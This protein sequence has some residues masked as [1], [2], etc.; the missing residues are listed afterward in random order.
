MSSIQ[1]CAWASKHGS[2]SLLESPL[3]KKVLVTIAELYASDLAFHSHREAVV[4]TLRSRQCVETKGGTLEFPTDCYLNEASVKLFKPAHNRLIASWLESPNAIKLL[5]DVG[6]RDHVSID[7]LFSSLDSLDCTEDPRP[8]VKYLLTIQ[9]KL[10]QSEWQQLKEAR[11][12][13]STSDEKLYAPSELVLRYELQPSL[14]GTKYLKWYGR[15]DADE[16]Q[17]LRRL[18]VRNRARFTDII[19]D[20]VAAN[21][22]LLRVISSEKAYMD[23]AQTSQAR[24]IP[25]IQNGETIVCSLNGCYTN[26]RWMSVGL[27]VVTPEVRRESLG[28]GVRQDPPIKDAVFALLNLVSKVKAQATGRNQEIIMDEAFEAMG[29]LSDRLANDKVRTTLVNAPIV[30]VAGVWYRPADVYIQKSNLFPSA[31][32]CVFLRS[33]GV[34]DFPAPQDIATVMLRDPV[35]V[36]GAIGEADYINN[37]RIIAN[38]FA[39]LDSSLTQTMKR[40]RWLIGCRKYGLTE[41]RKLVRVD[42]V[43]L[44]DNTTLTQFQCWG[45]PLENGLEKMYEALGCVKLSSKVQTHRRVLGKERNTVASEAI[46][47]RLLERR[48]ILLDRKLRLPH[49]EKLL[50]EDMDV[51]E[52]DKIIMVLKCDGE[53][54]SSEVCCALS[55]DTRNLKL[56]ITNSVDYYELAEALGETLFVAFKFEDRFLLGTILSM[57]VEQLRKRGLPVDRRIVTLSDKPTEPKEQYIPNGLS[58]TDQSPNS[59]TLP[60]KKTS[61][62]SS[63]S[64]KLRNASTRLPPRSQENSAP[65]ETKHRGPA[66]PAVRKRSKGGGLLQR[67]LRSITGSGTSGSST[68]HNLVEASPTSSWKSN[69]RHSATYSSDSEQHLRTRQ[70]LQ[71]AVES[72]TKVSS[73]G[74]KSR[75]HMVRKG[76]VSNTPY[77]C[78]VIPSQDLSPLKGPHGSTRSQKFQIRT[79]VARGN[80]EAEAK[81]KGMWDVVETF[82]AVLNVLANVYEVPLRSCAIFYEPSGRTIAFNFNGS[83]FFN[84]RFF[85]NLHGGEARALRDPDVYIYW[86]LTFAHELAHQI[87]SEHNQTHSHFMTSFIESYF[88]KFIKTLQGQGVSALQDTR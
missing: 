1:W 63:G 30:L 58:H 10:T 79:F 26:S 44:I 19:S 70:T 28:L 72:C 73:K 53:S 14:S 4:K 45:C 32:D 40:S 31:K 8:L 13:P 5:R 33:L 43:V 12:L 82:S 38:E 68:S 29:R 16:E 56:Q 2:L 17:L 24:F 75:E 87:E 85:M 51:L 76:K 49:G 50:S 62:I 20:G 83:L 71:A 39:K 18:G 59:A 69:N 48:G 21:A 74:V 80:E 46:K 61:S 66:P 7:V 6:A 84:V 64:D 37:L 81:I 9:E 15:R 60:A 52:V 27:A 42:E 34:R 55:V 41:K 23:A 54:R 36:I 3:R 11:Y 86:Y 25:C 22:E 67:T 77:S 78:E 35:K 88:V 65:E 57:S 47:T